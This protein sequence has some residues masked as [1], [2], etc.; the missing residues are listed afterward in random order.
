MAALGAGNCRYRYD[1]LALVLPDD[2]GGAPVSS[3][4]DGGGKRRSVIE[5]GQS[6]SVLS[7]SVQ[8]VRTAF[9]GKLIAMRLPRNPENCVIG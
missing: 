7:L 9:P 1:H 6:R 4:D 5:R 8:L 3:I 2:E